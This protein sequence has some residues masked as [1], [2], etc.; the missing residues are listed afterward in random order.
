MMHEILDRLHQLPSI[1][2]VVQELII[3]FEDPD[4]DSQHLAEKISHDQAISAKVLR[5]ANSAFYGLPRQVGSIQEAVVVLGFGAVRSL[6]LCAGIVDAFSLSE[7]DCVDRNL[8]W[9]HSLITASYAKSVAKCLR[10]DG[11]MAFSTGLLHDIGVLVLDVCDHERFAKLWHDA[12]G[13]GEAL[14]RAERAALGFDHAELGAEVVRRWRFP[15]AIEDAIRYHYQP[16]CVPSQLLTGIVQL[17]ALLAH[18]SEENLPEREWLENIPQ[19]LCNAL[20]LDW[21]SLRDCLPSPEQL[22]AATNQ[23]LM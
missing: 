16:E 9:K 2:A 23:I 17:A 8:Y 14:I 4:L 6:V 12:P 20:N 10:Q 7:P 1:P 19:S 18:F 11:E 13:R 3:S 21:D 22:E 15:L 5:V